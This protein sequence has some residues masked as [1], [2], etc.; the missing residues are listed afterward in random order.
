[1]QRRV[2]PQFEF[3]L[4]TPPRMAYIVRQKKHETESIHSGIRMGDILEPNRIEER[5]RGIATGT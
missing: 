4:P 1:M 2:T 5:A 3:G